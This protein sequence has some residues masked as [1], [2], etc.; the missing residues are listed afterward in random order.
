VPAF[1]TG[2]SNSFWREIHGKTRIVAV[3][4]EPVELPRIEGDTRL[5]H[6]KRTADLLNDRIAALFDEERKLRGG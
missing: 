1:I 2:L 5:T 3:F 6:H 4:G